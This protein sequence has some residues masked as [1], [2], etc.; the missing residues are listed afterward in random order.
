M[1]KQFS[2]KTAA[3]HYSFSEVF[4]RKLVTFKKVAYH[5][6]GRSV[7][8]NKSDLDKYFLDRMKN[9]KNRTKGNQ[10]NRKTA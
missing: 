5:H 8:F 7:R 10:N 2:C 6:I 4:F 1:D 3:E 9:D